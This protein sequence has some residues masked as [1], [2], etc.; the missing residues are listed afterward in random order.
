MSDAVARLNATLE[1]RLTLTW[2]CSSDQYFPVS[3]RVAELA[4]YWHTR[5]AV[6]WRFSKGVWLTGTP[7]PAVSPD[8]TSIWRVA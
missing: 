1:G 4:H 3:P 7:G 2:G 8:L 6:I 5:L